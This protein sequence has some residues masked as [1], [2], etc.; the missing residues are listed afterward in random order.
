MGDI[1]DLCRGINNQTLR[2]KEVIFVD[3]GSPEGYLYH[4]ESVLQVS[5]NLPYRVISQ[6]NRGL[7]AARNTGW[8]SATTPYVIAHDADKILKPDFVWHGVAYLE[9]NKNCAAVTS[10]M[11][12]FQDGDEFETFNPEASKSTPMFTSLITGLRENVFCDAMACYRVES[13]SEIGGWDDSDKSRWEDWA[14]HLKLTSSGCRI[15]IVNSYQFLSRIRQDAMVKT[16]TTY[17]AECRLARNLVG[18]PRFEAFSLMRLACDNFRFNHELRQLTGSLTYRI[19]RRV[20]GLLNQ[21]PSLKSPLKSTITI[22]WKGLKMV[23][24]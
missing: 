10:Y 13:L 6:P 8:R 2:P 1:T 22:L 9:K 15:G 19:A 16:D 7:A 21:V 11:E 23:R 17:L 4:L 14:L 18:L 5:L 24:Q 20:N 3:D 12:Q